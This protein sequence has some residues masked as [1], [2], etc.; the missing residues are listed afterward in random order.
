MPETQRCGFV[1]LAHG[2]TQVVKHLP[3]HTVLIRRNIGGDTT[4][5]DRKIIVAALLICYIIIIIEYRASKIA[6]R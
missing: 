1:V 2:E 4:K 6:H 3:E 5:P